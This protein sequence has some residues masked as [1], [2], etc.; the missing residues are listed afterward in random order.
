MSFVRRAVLTLRTRIGNATK[1]QR[2]FVICSLFLMAVY[3][4]YLLQSSFSSSSIV[5]GD[6]D[7]TFLNTNPQLTKQLVKLSTQYSK[8]ISPEL[9]LA[10]QES[11]GFFTDISDTQWN[12]MKLKA[13]A[14]Q[15]NTRGNPLA[16]TSPNAWFQNHYEPEFTCL[17]ERRIGRLGDGG[18]WVCD[19]HR[20]TAS[21]DS[22]LVYSVGSNGDASYEAAILQDVSP[23]CEIHVFDFGN[24]AQSVAQ[25][26]NHNPNVHYH[27]WGI[28]DS[29]EGVFQTLKDTVEK[30][31][32][33][34]RTIDIFKIDCEGCELDTVASWFDANVTLQQIVVEL[35]PSM[36]LL[37]R[38]T[39][40]LPET[41][42]F[43]TTLHKHGYVITHKEPNIQYQ[44]A[45]L[46]VEYNF[47]LTSPE[48]WTK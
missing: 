12:M 42:H 39:M 1:Q 37:W 7:L 47:L 46:C 43:F 16:P 34:G 18:K 4:K 10:F 21:H 29:T 40:K 22:C 19:P 14:M 13:H 31:G 8:D 45:G 30:L 33:G 32:H 26:T 27:A 23:N 25:Q 35:H 6:A 41:V 3:Y 9:L 17:L 24:Y 48:F 28:S 15:P 36:S 5:M 38:P 11:H 20:I 44:G 2:I